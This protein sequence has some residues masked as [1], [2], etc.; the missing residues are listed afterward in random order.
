MDWS[1]KQYQ[2]IDFGRGRK[3]ESFGNVLVDR[4]CPAADG[5]QPKSPAE[6][7]NSQIKVDS[8][9][10]VVK[11]LQVLTQ[12][13]WHKLKFALRLT[14]FGHVGLFPEQQANWQWLV[15][16]AGSASQPAKKA[17][18]LFAYTG[19]TSLALASA[20]V[21]VT[22]VDASAPAVKWARR[23]AELS[24]LAEHPIRWIVEDARKFVAREL[25]RGN[26]YDMV[27]L[28]PPSFGHGPTGKPWEI[29]TDLPQLLDNT[30]K[31][32]SGS[33]TPLLLITAHSKMPDERTIS[34]MVQRASEANDLEHLAH[35]E[36]GRLHLT[37]LHRRKLDAGFFVRL[38]RAS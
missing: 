5:T 24:Q 26:H 10:K 37:D 22:H 32:I 29:E 8:R 16:T 12:V 33:S 36:H 25:K 17:L 18:N 4:P 34:T 3:L 11:E 38:S 31:L 14:P 13:S 21:E 27:I 15:E 28:D 9:G 7:T 2:L 20:G 35:I 6:W 23:N 1:P 30:I 19:G